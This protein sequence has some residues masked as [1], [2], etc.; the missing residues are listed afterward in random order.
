MANLNGSPTNYVAVDAAVNQDSYKYALE[1]IFSPTD[2]SISSATPLSTFLTADPNN[3][4]ATMY[5]KSSYPDATGT[6]Q[7]T[8]VAPGQTPLSSDDVEVSNEQVGFQG[9]FLSYLQNTYGPYTA[10][11]TG[12]STTYDGVNYPIVAVQVLDD[13]GAG[14][15][16][17]FALT[18]DPA[19][20]SSQTPTT[21]GPY[22]YSCFEK[23]TLIETSCG[24]VPVSELK[25]GDK[26]LTSDG[27]FVDVKWI[28]Y[29][30]LNPLFAK[31]HNG[32]PIKITSGSLGNGLPSNDLFVS[33]DHG[34]FVDGLLVNASALINDQTIYQ[35]S[36]WSGN[37][38]YY[39]IETE[40]HEIIIAEGVPVESLLDNLGR[41]KFANYKDFERLYP[42][43][44]VT[45]EL[46]IARVKV[47]RQ[48]PECT[49]QKLMRIAS[50]LG[51]RAKQV[52]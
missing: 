51:N 4:V 30:A 48:L 17:Y 43:G 28:G 31:M 32:M 40:N 10:T 9:S 42:N 25:L 33:P 13:P 29:R 50:E 19:G 12:W 18:N 26:V 21:L 38:E 14:E 44:K 15:T 35:V 22:Y 52:A 23:N 8:A 41:E 49:K 11:Y 46:D 1:V 47:A 2:G 5:D 20:V 7:P 37:V 36:S 3:I 16:H 39:H 6:A 27:R 45:Q 34:L 24:Q